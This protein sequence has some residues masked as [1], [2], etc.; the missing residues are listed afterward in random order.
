MINYVI[1][2]FKVL[3]LKPRNFMP[4]CGDFENQISDKL[5]KIHN[6]WKKNI[7]GTVT[8]TIN[9]DQNTKKGFK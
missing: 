3:S 6:E 9:Q 4:K 2:L 1:K 5:N 7:E 8:A